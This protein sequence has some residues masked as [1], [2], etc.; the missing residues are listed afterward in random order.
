MKKFSFQFE[1]LLR[2]RAFTEKEAKEALGREIGALNVIEAQIAEN[3]LAR[4]QAAQNRFA[5]NNSLSVIDVYDY[6]IKRLDT[7]RGRL[8]KEAELQNK[9]VD[10]ARETYIEASRENKIIEKLK[11]KQFTVYKKEAQ[12]AEDAEIDEL[13]NR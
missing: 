12:A 5:V 8:L 7:E 2:V 11:E 3:S 1:K 13:A 6:Y 4:E 9:K 10:E